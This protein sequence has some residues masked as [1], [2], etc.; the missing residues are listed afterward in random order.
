MTALSDIQRQELF[1]QTLFDEENNPT[2]SFEVAKQVAGYPESESITTILGRIKGELQD[3]MQD[4][5]LSR[6]PIAIN[7]LLAIIE[8]KEHIVNSDKVLAACKEILDRAGVSKKD[9]Q[10]IEVTMPEGVIVLP[11]LNIATREA[12]EYYDKEDKDSI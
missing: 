5:M 10:E 7:K 9:K 4:Y 1:I 12:K 2:Q 6:A 11:A 8:G 3:S